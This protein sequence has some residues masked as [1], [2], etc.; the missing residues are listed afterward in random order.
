MTTIVSLMPTQERF[1]ACYEAIATATRYMLEAARA[2]DFPALAALERDCNSWIQRIERLGD[3]QAVLDAQGRRRRI[4]LLGRTL[5]D[6]AAL[7]DLLE[8]WL[9]RVDRCLRAQPG[10]EMR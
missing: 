2:G 1:L 4:E 7:R 6:D 5:R 9:G 3:P 10:L 8:P